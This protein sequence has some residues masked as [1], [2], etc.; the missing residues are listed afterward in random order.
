MTRQELGHCVFC[1]TCQ[2]PTDLETATVR[3]L[4]HALEKEGLPLIAPKKKKSGEDGGAYAQN[5]F[6]NCC[7]AVSVVEKTNPPHALRWNPLV[8]HGK[9]KPDEVS[10]KAERQ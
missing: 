3:V 2:S 9:N 6:D 5:S 7:A 4:E 1:E 8:R 10:A